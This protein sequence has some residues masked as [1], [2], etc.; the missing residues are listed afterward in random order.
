M[1]SLFL[2]SETLTTDLQTLDNLLVLKILDDKGYELPQNFI[3]EADIWG[4]HLLS[5]ALNIIFKCEPEEIEVTRKTSN[6]TYQDRMILLPLEGYDDWARLKEK[7]PEMSEFEE[8]MCMLAFDCDF[9]G[10]QLSIQFQD[11]GIVIDYVYEISYLHTLM[12]D[13][14]T[15]KEMWVEALFIWRRKEFEENERSTLNSRMENHSTETVHE[16]SQCA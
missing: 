13:F 14:L 8:D 6:G 16:I 12:D 9:T 15:L 3:F 7:Y 11:K 10:T 1:K 5:M 2:T 4:D